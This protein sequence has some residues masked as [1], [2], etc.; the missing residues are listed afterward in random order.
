MK[1]NK[2]E[3]DLSD[4]PPDHELYDG[5]N[6]K[7]IGKMKN[8]SVNIIT[9]FIGLRSK[10]YSFIAEKEYK[11]HNKCKGVKKY[12]ADTFD[13]EDYEKTLITKEP[14]IISQ[15]CIRSH[16]H[17]LF[18]ETQNKIGLSCYD[19]KVYIDDDYINTYNFDHYKIRK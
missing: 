7:V 16:K 15:N 5:K 6:K 8:E 14:K 18:T 12:V 13:I 19:D 11:S 3:F 17:E 10:L 2:D 4:Y 9:K 1:D